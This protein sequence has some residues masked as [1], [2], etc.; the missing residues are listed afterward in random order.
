ML[1]AHIAQNIRKQVLYYLQATFDFRDK[2]VNQAF[3]RFLEDPDTGLFNGPW[4]QL[5][6]PFNP[7]HKDADIPFDIKTPFHP[8][9][10]QYRAWRRLSSLNQKPR[11]TI[12]TTGTG[13]GK[14]ECFLFPILDHCLRKMQL[15]F[16]REVFILFA[17]KAIAAL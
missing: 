16:T 9:L 17:V 4:V 5:K 7:A 8:F 14:T 15:S 12:V 13:S 6:R 2:K 10:H 11:N 1:P 3:L